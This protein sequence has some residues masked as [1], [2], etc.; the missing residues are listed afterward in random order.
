MT[1]SGQVWKVVGGARQGGILVRTGKELSSPETSSRLA[2]GALVLQ[3]E[4]QEERLRY[5]KL[6]GEGPAQGWVSLKLKGSDLLVKTEE[7]SIALAPPASNVAARKVRILAL[8]GQASNSSFMKFQCAPLKTLLGKDAEWFFVDGPVP[9]EQDM[10]TEE[11]LVQK[12][13]EMEVRLCGNKALKMWFKHGWTGKYD[14]V[15]EAFECLKNHLNQNAP[16]DVLLCFSHGANLVTMYQD[17]LRAKGLAVPWRLNVFFCAGQVDD[18]KWQFT[19]PLALPTLRI[20]NAQ[21][22]PWFPDGELSLS[23]LY[24]NITERGHQDG[25]AFPSSQPLAGELLA[26]V[27][28]EIR[29]H[30]V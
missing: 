18:P 1:S 7:A 6:Q 2:S 24:S 25:H 29:R 11:S 13:T 19:E 21:S 10:S 9:W 14:L 5:E 26:L 20:F 30:C 8:H 15:N 27:Q 17:E 3:I 12:R 28:A 4:L 23:H 22:D 16:I